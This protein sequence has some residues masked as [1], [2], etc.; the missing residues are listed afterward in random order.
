M[1]TEETTEEKELLSEEREKLLKVKEERIFCLTL[2][3]FFEDVPK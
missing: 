1:S 2:V 3:L